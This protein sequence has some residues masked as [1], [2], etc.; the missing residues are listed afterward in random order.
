MSTFQERL[1]SVIGIGGY[2]PCMR[3]SVQSVLLVEAQ[4]VSS[5]G[6][7]FVAFCILYSQFFQRMSIAC[8]RLFFHC[9]VKFLHLIYMHAV[10]ERQASLS[11][12]LSEKG[13][14]LGSRWVEASCFYCSDRCAMH[15]MHIE[16]PLSYTTSL[17]FLLKPL[18]YWTRWILFLPITRLKLCGGRRLRRRYSRRMQP[19]NDRV[20]LKE[21]LLSWQKK[22]SLT[23]REILM[24]KLAI[25]WY[26]SY[27]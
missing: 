16:R 3:R 4:R 17:P 26:R 2:E 22:S 5:K 19:G 25:C 6:I 13:G 12:T 21:S 1:K 11:P 18:R 24:R 23:W 27:M 14:I 8:L 9:F 20:W 10:R 15:S 7:L